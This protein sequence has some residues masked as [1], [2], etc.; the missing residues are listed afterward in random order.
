MTKSGRVGNKGEEVHGRNDKAERRIAG[1][2]GGAEGGEKKIPSVCRLSYVHLILLIK[3]MQIQKIYLMLSFFR[4][5][6]FPL[7]G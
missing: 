5:V 3:C 1:A 2:G 4:G 7:D 6:F